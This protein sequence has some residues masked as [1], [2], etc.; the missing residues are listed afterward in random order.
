MYPA[1]CFPDQIIERRKKKKRERERLTC[2][3]SWIQSAACGAYASKYRRHVRRRESTAINEQIAK[4]NCSYVTYMRMVRRPDMIV[5]ICVCSQPFSNHYF[6]FSSDDPPP[7]SPP[8]LT[9]SRRQSR[10]SQSAALRIAVVSSHHFFF[11]FFF[12]LF[13]LRFFRLLGSALHLCRPSG[14]VING[15]DDGSNIPLLASIRHRAK[16]NTTM[17]KG[18]EERGRICRGL[19]RIQVICTIRI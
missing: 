15:N 4:A 12:V 5:H 3:Y 19:H 14:R 16:R 1:P 18:N 11:L 17:T 9:P 7:P 6:S 8:P 13:R 10:S 2:A